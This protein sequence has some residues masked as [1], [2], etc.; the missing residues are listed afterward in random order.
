MF[1]TAAG[2]LLLA[3]LAVDVLQSTIGYG[4]G[5]F[6]DRIS[7]RM[8][9]VLTRVGCRTGNRRLLAAIGFIHIASDF[10][11]WL[12]AL[13]AGWSL[14]FCGTPSAVVAGDGGGPA[15]YADRIYFAGYCISTLG[16]GDFRPG[17]PGWQFAAVLASL[18]GLV[19]VTFLLSVLIGI[20]QAAQSRRQTAIYI[21]HLG[22]SPVEIV[23]DSFDGRSCDPLKPHLD[24]LTA[25]LSQLEQQHRYFP[26]MHRFHSFSPREDIGVALVMLSEAMSILMVGIEGDPLVCPFTLE[27]TQRALHGFLATTDVLPMSADDVVLPPAPLGSLRETGVPVVDAATFE[28]RLEPW[29]PYRVRMNRVLTSGG[30]S[31]D[32]IHRGVNDGDAED[33]DA[34]ARGRAKDRIVVP[35]P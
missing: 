19:L 17:G 7:G 2:C 14:V 20:L 33:G 15:G 18:S 12:A 8:T 28:S 27:K 32:I 22:A 16:I 23:T 21:R 25:E 10:L 35:R 13:W 3:M 9:D 6:V 30:W 11:L 4:N 29:R 1:L 5:P 34:E 24:A 26:I 31:W